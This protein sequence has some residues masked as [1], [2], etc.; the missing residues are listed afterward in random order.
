MLWLPVLLSVLWLSS[1][2]DARAADSSADPAA[3]WQA[4]GVLAGGVVG[5]AAVALAWARLSD[6]ASALL[7]ALLRER[8]EAAVA[9]VAARVDVLEERSE[10]HHRAIYGDEHQGGVLDRLRAMQAAQEEALDHLA[11][12]RRDAIEASDRH[13][14]AL[15]ELSAT[16]RRGG[17]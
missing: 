3:M 7:W 2:G 6:A 1:C 16:V 8:A 11:Q 13:T 14:A 12:L 9:T 4:I 10:T 15:R 5:L 17:G